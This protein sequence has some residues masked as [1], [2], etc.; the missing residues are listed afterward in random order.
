MILWWN[1]SG[2]VLAC[3]RNRGGFEVAP[4][5]FTGSMEIS[6]ELGEIVGAFP[7]FHR[8]ADGIVEVTEDEGQT[9]AAAELPPLPVPATITR[10]Q[11]RKWLL[12]EELLASVEA[13]IAAAGLAA[14]IDYEAPTWY[15]DSPLIAQLGAALG[16]TADEI[17]D[18]F[19]E[20][21]AL[22]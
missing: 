11:G 3:H 20:A 6:D 18:F 4:P 2:E 7:R 14:Q 13:M 10:W 19:R 12:Q 9:W 17:D 21:A 16:K 1:E 8:V 22:A 5:E 15:R